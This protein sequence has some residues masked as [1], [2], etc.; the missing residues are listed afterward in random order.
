M[1]TRYT[2]WVVV[3]LLGAGCAPRQER[4]A[5]N[6]KV[7]VSAPFVDVNVAEQGGVRVRAPFTNID[8]TSRYQQTGVSSYNSPPFSGGAN[9]RFQPPGSITTYSPSATNAPFQ[10]IGAV[11]Q[12]SGNRIPS[13]PVLP[14]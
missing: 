9:V 11:G 3:A 5:D 10:P 4:Y 13:A 8:T 1:F 6:S 12:P 7:S 14:R 2:R